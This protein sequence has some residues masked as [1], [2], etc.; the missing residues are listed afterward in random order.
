MFQRSY[1]GLYQEHS[2]YQGSN[3]KLLHRVIMMLKNTQRGVHH[4]VIRLQGYV[5]EYVYRF[6]KRSL[7]GY[8]LDDLLGKMVDE[9]P[10]TYKQ[11]PYEIDT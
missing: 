1:P 3:F 5:D 6:N 11:L 2:G 8:M 10:I 7:G 9:L 4:A